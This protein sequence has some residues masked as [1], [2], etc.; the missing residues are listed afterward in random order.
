MSHSFSSYLH[1]LDRNATAYNEFFRWQ[2]M[3]QF[4]DTKF[5]CRICAMMQVPPR[6]VYERLDRWWHSS[7]DCKL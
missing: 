2:S 3:G 6:K 1:Y 5:W 4:V 7:R